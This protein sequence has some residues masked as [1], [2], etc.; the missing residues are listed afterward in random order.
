M[1]AVCNSQI[2][3][4]PLLCSKLQE[5]AS[6]LAAAS[7]GPVA[8]AAVSAGTRT[9][10]TIMLLNAATAALS[11]AAALSH[12]MERSQIFRLSLAAKPVLEL[13]P[14]HLRELAPMQQRDLLLDAAEIQIL[15]F[16]A[17]LALV[18]KDDGAA[19]AFAASVAAPRSLLTWATEAT[20]A[21]ALGTAGGGQ[22]LGEC[23]ALHAG[24]EG[25]LYAWKASFV[26]PPPMCQTRRCA[27]PGHPAALLRGHV[28]CAYTLGL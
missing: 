9:D 22:S 25:R 12:R 28:L 8:T 24:R 20:T 19:A 15:A 3:C 17:C 26:T 2:P 18:R 16:D 5:V 4:C 7:S 14:A 11:L 23:H 1:I 21:L 27:R 6:L 10:A 13:G